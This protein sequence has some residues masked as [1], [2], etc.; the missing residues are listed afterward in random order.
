MEICQP[1][2]IIEIEIEKLGKKTC[3][4]RLFV[5]LRPCIDGFLAGCRPYIGVDA[6][7]LKVK[8]TGQ[9][10]SVTSVDG[11]NWLYHLVYGIFHSKTEDNWV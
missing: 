4:K 8:Y 9:L 5:A 6:S 11:R 7:S 2:S 1:G 10:A 3:F